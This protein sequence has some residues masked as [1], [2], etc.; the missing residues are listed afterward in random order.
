MAL[1][2]QISTVHLWSNYL[3]SLLWL[4]FVIIVYNY[5]LN[6]ISAG[7]LNA[8][9]VQCACTFYITKK[10]CEKWKINWIFGK[11]IMNQVKL[12]NFEPK[13]PFHGEIAIW[14]SV[15]T[16]RTIRVNLI[17]YGRYDVSIC[18]LLARFMLFGWHCIFHLFL[19]LTSDQHLILL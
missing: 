17:W 4:S 14:K 11:L 2:H 1:Y 18:C 7:L 16:L 10:H 13:D 15:G 12:R 9:W 3:I 5:Y 8:A 6:P 19:G